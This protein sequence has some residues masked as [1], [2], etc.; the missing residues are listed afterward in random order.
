M[1]LFVKLKLIQILG[2]AIVIILFFCDFKKT[3]IQK[4]GI[5]L[6]PFEYSEKP[7]IKSPYITKDTKELLLCKTNNSKYTIIPVTVE[8]GKPFNYRGK[9]R[10]KGNQLYIDSID[11]PTLAKTGLHSESDLQ[12]IKSITGRSIAE[13]TMRGRP[14]RMS[15]AGFMAEDEDIVSVLSGDNILVKKMNLT[16]PELAKTIFHYWNIIQISEEIS[17]GQGVNV[18][19]IDT[20]FYNNRI[21]KYIIPS[22]RGWQDSV[23]EDS[24]M[25]ECHLEM[26]IQLSEKE[27]DFI[28]THFNHLTNEQKEDLVKKLTHMHTGEMVAYYIQRYGFYEG[29]TD[30]R[31]NPIVLAFIF[32]LKSLEELYETF[33]GKVYENIINH[34]VSKF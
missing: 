16:H 18:P 22:C 6:Y 3:G 5:Q 8:K 34:H 21:I 24:I 32:G 15:G 7:E 2:I 19:S 17:I 4:S 27:K 29:H 31:A 12:N 23:F 25:G 1:R 26:K 20:I 9:V 11:F 30:Y 33:D 10:G 13:I 14:M 28:E